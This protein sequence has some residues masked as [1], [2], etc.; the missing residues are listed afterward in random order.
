MNLGQ[1]TV[2]KIIDRNHILNA[3]E[4]LGPNLVP[5][6]GLKWT[7]LM[8]LNERSLKRTVLDNSGRSIGP[9]SK[10]DMVVYTAV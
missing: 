5:D 2:T 3:D 10:F 1:K 4:I 7:F 6:Q 8:S 9:G